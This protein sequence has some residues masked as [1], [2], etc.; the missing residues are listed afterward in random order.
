MK[1]LERT[2]LFERSPQEF[3]ERWYPQEQTLS[4]KI[5]QAREL[6]PNVIY[7]Q[8]D[9][10]TVAELMAEMKVDGHRGDIVILKT[11]LAHAAFLGRDRVTLEDILTAAELALPHRLKRLPFQ[12]TAAEFQELSE[13]LQQIRQESQDKVDQITETSDTSGTQK[14]KTTVNQ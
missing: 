12:D 4:E 3:S 6:L 1:I 10:Y 7:T 2:L 9:I 5:I 13:R 8:R 14:K 11:A